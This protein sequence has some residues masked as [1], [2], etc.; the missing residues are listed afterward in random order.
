VEWTIAIQRR[1]RITRPTH[2]GPQRRTTPPSPEQ[3]QGRLSQTSAGVDVANHG[4]DQPNS[5]R[6]IF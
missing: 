3:R 1:S 5:R 6:T 2:V 4:K